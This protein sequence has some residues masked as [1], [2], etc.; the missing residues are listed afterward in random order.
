VRDV[1]AWADNNFGRNIVLGSNTSLYHLDGIGVVT[2]ITPSDVVTTPKDASLTAGYGQNPYGLGA[3]GVENDVTGQPAIPP[4]RWVYDVFGQLLLYAQRGAG[5]IFVLDPITLTSVDISTDFGAPDA[6]QDIVVTDQ[7][8]VIALAPQ[9][10]PRRVVWSDQEDFSQWVP[11]IDNQA[12][13]FDIVG[14][15]RLLRAI[16]VLNQVLI[17]SE[18]DAHVARYIGPPLV[19]GF[20]LVGRNCGPITPYSVIGTERFAVWLGRRNFWI[21]DGS[22]KL[23][24]CEVMDFLI[25]DIN[26][27]QISKIF[28]MTIQEFNEVWWFYQ[29]NSAT[30]VDSY[31]T[32]DY[33]A[34]VWHTGRLA[35]TAGVD[36]GTLRSPVMVSPD[37]ILFNHEQRGVVPNGPVF[38]ESGEID[39][40][41]GERN[42]AVR[43]IY[44]DSENS[45]DYTVTILG[46][47][48]PTAQEFTYGPYPYN[49]PIPTRAIGRS[50][51]VRYDAVAPG[52]EVGIS[53][54]EVSP[55]G[56]KR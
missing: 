12:G 30:E 11:A 18:N 34:N 17:L 29:S 45:G 28:T 6:V 39:V 35:R 13:D 56:G 42:V 47:Q 32:W 19:F 31:V 8:I 44:P 20:D 38:I 43:Y 10:N 37:G 9:G 4:S 27:P 5:S 53:R 40:A 2:D 52:F 7:R 21:F 46:K 15:G 24:D 51:K 25:Q 16:N 50:I 26:V 14:S 33:A 3:Y 22:L 49:N 48:F 23:L 1:L 55:Y 41:N 54:L 36:A